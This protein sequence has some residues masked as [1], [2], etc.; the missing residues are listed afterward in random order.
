MIDEA[1]LII[2]FIKENR[3][4][5]IKELEEAK[6]PKEKFDLFV[7][8]LDAIPNPLLCH[9]LEIRLFFDEI[10]R[11]GLEWLYQERIGRDKVG[12]IAK[13]ARGPSLTT[14]DMQELENL[15]N[16]KL[17]SKFLDQEGIKKSFWVLSFIRKT[18]FLKEET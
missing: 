15:H 18:S 6:M 3:P 13:K 7:A 16:K 17:R 14:K 1:F 12:A 2:D 11:G 9:P 4:R 10:I 8:R 5:L